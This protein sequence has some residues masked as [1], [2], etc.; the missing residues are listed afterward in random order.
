MTNNVDNREIKY[1]SD[2]LS[3]EWRYLHIVFKIMAVE[4]WSILQYV[5]CIWYVFRNIIL[6]R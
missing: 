3:L 6:A 2:D 5:L 4:Q 1:K